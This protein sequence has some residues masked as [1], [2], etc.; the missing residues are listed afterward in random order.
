MGALGVPLSQGSAPI[1]P[2][3]AGRSITS[4][5]KPTHGQIVGQ[6]LASFLVGLCEQFCSDC[7]RQ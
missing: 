1:M 7:L 5:F 3:T 2:S 6:S 4:R